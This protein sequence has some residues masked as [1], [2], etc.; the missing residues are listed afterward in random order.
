MLF[1]L[2]LPQTFPFYL[3]PSLYFLAIDSTPKNINALI[4][5]DMCSAI[6]NIL[7]LVVLS[8]TLN[9]MLNTKKAIAIVTMF[10]PIFLSSITNLYEK[11]AAPDNMIKENTSTI[12]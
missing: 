2:L 9:P 11:N 5:T 6:S 7:I 12:L 1:P 8:K 3:R 10:Q 4:I